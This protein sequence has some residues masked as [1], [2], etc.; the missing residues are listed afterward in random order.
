MHVLFIRRSRLYPSS[1]PSHPQ[2]HL[3]QLTSQYQPPHSSSP[4]LS[5]QSVSVSPEAH[6]YQNHSYHHHPQTTAHPPHS[7]S[8]PPL[9]PGPPRHLPLHQLAPVLYYP[10]LQFHLNPNHHPHPSVSLA[11]SP[12]SIVSLSPS[13]TQQ[14]P[15]APS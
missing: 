10:T 2:T 6:P 15:P 7:S 9:L 1:R 14:V 5:S 12:Q 3:A 8:F 4:L 11:Y 13:P